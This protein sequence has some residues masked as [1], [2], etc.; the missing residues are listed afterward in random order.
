MIQSEQALSF[1][2]NFNRLVLH[3]SPCIF[4]ASFNEI[5]FLIAFP[6]SSTY[7]VDPFLRRGVTR[8]AES[9]TWAR[10]QL[11]CDGIV[12]LLSPKYA[13]KIMLI[14]PKNEVISKKNV[15]S[16]ISTVFPAR[17]K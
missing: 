5:S 9:R 17:I 13:E 15:F 6:E 10:G 16:K 1:S 12:V 11:K 7:D 8:G 4:I 2:S 14:G 3:L